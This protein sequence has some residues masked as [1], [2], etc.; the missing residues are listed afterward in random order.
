MVADDILGTKCPYLKLWGLEQ[1]S[2]FSTLETKW[3]ST[4]TG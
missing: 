2:E 3:K 4:D 1:V